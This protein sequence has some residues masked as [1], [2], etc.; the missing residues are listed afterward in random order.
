MTLADFTQRNAPAWLNRTIQPTSSN[1][2]QSCANSF[3]ACMW[4]HCADFCQEDASDR[5]SSNAKSGRSSKSS[6]GS[7]RASNPH[8]SLPPSTLPKH[9]SRFD[10]SGT[11]TVAAPTGGAMLVD[12]GNGESRPLR[13]A[14]SALNRQHSSENIGGGSSSSSSG[15]INGQRASSRRSFPPVD[16]I[17]TLTSLP[18]RLGDVK[19]T[20]ESLKGQTFPVKAIVVAVPQDGLENSGRAGEAKAYAVPSWLLEDP[21]VCVLRTPQDWGPATKLVGLSQHLWLQGIG[22]KSRGGTHSEVSHNINQSTAIHSVRSG[23]SVYSGGGSTGGASSHL[24][25]GNGGHS[26]LAQEMSGV[27]KL[28]LLVVDDDTW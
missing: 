6:N 4:Y 2:A 10:I 17:A 27:N 23:S 9:L 5:S 21:S 25:S 24:S 15:S 11:V 3:A 26:E 13:L 7:K 1:S 16:V 8:A 19:A 20:I 28:R 18:S 12:V 14:P 22:G